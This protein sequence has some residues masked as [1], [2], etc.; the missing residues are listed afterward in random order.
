MRNWEANQKFI[1][2]G[3]LSIDSWSRPDYGLL[4][5]SEILAKV[6]CELQYWL[7][8]YCDQLMNDLLPAQV[9]PIQNFFLPHRYE[10]WMLELIRGEVSEMLI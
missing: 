2:D 4:C 9:S 6:H 8:Q 7:Q 10:Y 1:K 3:Q 5:D